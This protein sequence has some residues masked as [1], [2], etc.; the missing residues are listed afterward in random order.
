MYTVF[1]ADSG[2]YV[3]IVQGEDGAWYDISDD[4][5]TPRAAPAAD[6]DYIA[7][8]ATQVFYR[9]IPK[10]MHGVGA[11]RWGRSANEQKRRRKRKQRRSGNGR[12]ERM[13][14]LFCN[15]TKG[16]P[17]ARRRQWRRGGHNCFRR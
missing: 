1:S 12:R 8:H 5:V 7:R 17:G 13:V 11:G 9:R 2:H 15:A 3:A 10:D 6:D 4:R 14:L 16:V